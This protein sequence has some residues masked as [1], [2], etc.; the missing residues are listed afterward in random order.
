MILGPDIASEQN[1]SA[2]YPLM[3][4]FITSER[5]TRC[6]LVHDRVTIDYVRTH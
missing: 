3:S 6:A 4:P 2:H 5:M 1:F